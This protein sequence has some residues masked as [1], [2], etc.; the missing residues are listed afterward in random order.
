[1]H[2]RLFMRALSGAAILFAAGLGVP[3]AESAGQS[4]QAGQAGATGAD[5]ALA[6]HKYRKSI[7]WETVRVPGSV[8]EKFRAIKEAGFEG[9]ELSSHMNR[10]EVLDAVRDTGL[11][12]TGVVCSTHWRKPLSHPEAAV[13]REAVEGVL[14][15]IEDARVYGTDAVLLVPGRVDATVS[16]DECWERSVEGIRELIPVAEKSGIFI[17]IENV[18]NGF[19]LSPLEARRYVDQFGSGCVKFYFDTGNVMTH[20]WPEQ[21]LRILGGRT[22][23]AHI[24]DYSVKIADTQGRR[25]GTSAPLGGGDVDWPRV[26]Q[27]LR[28]HY[29]NDWLTVEHGRSTTVGELRELRERFEKVAGE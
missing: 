20:G 28:E 9:V 8:M 16:Y 12:V 2:L 5:G 4:R 13:R 6:R 3:A 21:W 15:A 22:G 29:K 27:A 25:A 11:S 7:M 14:V 19:L 24:K 18:W 17:C 26:M 1:M 23:R 10:Q